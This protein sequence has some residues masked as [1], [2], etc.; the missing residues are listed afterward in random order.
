[1]TARNSTP[2]LLTISLSLVLIHSAI[3]PPRP[4]NLSHYLYPKVTAFTESDIPLHPPHF[5]QGV[6]DSISN[7]EKWA[8]EDFWVSELDVKKAKFKTVQRYGF[9]VP[10]GKIEVA[11]KMHDEASEWKKL[12]RLSENGASNFE[13]LARRIGSTAVIDSFKAEGPLE[14]MVVGE[15][16]RLSLTFPLNRSHFGLRRILV[17]EGISVE[18]KGAEEISLFN[19][20]N[21]QFMYGMFSYRRWSDVGSIWPAIC[22]RLLPI[23]IHGSASVVAYRSGRPDNPKAAAIGSLKVRISAFPMYRFPLELRRNIRTNDSYWSTLAE[24]RTRPATERVR[25]E[26]VARIEG[27]VLKPL[28]IKKVRPLNTDSFSWSSLS[29][30]L[31]FTELPPLLLPPESL[32]LDVKW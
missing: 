25:F 30:N 10:V 5:L 9:R 2:F 31:S 23:R 20:S 29:S 3:I 16:D 24:W 22:T 6:L 18:V 27:E 11:L 21:Y 8:L 7:K 1:M 14:L 15:D 28:V 19:P 12:V 17:G 26:V 13:A 4:F 32:T